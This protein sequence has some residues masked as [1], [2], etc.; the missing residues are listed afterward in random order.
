MSYGRF[1]CGVIEGFYNQQRAKV[2][3]KERVQITL[4]K[5]SHPG[6]PAYEAGYGMG[7][8]WSKLGAVRPPETRAILTWYGTWSAPTTYI[9]PV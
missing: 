6:G 8:E 2:S 1:L 7:V 3:F 9:G 4:R 5:K